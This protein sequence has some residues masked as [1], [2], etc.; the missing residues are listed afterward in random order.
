MTLLKLVMIIKDSGEPLKKTL[1]TIKPY[2]DSWCILDTGSVDESKKIVKDILS[3][4]PGKLYEEN[5]VD[6]ATSR[7]RAFKLAENTGIECKYNIVLEPN[8]ILYYISFG[9]DLKP[10]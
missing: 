9:N 6:F 2:I 3:N 8:D 4:I 5:F 7:N 10:T 1:E